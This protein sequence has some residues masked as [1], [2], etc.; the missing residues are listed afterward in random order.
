MHFDLSVWDSTAQETKEFTT[1]QRSHCSQ[2]APWYA[3]LSSF[4][5]A[6]ADE[7]MRVLN[8]RCIDPQENDI[9]V[10]G[11]QCALLLNRRDVASTCHK[12]K[13]EEEGIVKSPDLLLD[14]EQMAQ[15]YEEHAGG[16]NIE[17][18][19]ITLRVT[20]CHDGVPLLNG[21]ND[22]VI[23]NRLRCTVLASKSR[24]MR[25]LKRTIPFSL[26]NHDGITPGDDLVMAKF[27][28]TCVQLCELSWADFGLDMVGSSRCNDDED[29]DKHAKT[30]A[31]NI[32]HTRS[33]E[34]ASSMHHLHCAALSCQRSNLESID[35]IVNIQSILADNDYWKTRDSIST[36]L[37]KKSFVD[38]PLVN[39]MIHMLL[40]SVQ[41]DKKWLQSK[42]QIKVGR[43]DFNVESKHDNAD[44]NFTSLLQSATNSVSAIYPHHQS[45]H[46]T[47][48]C[49]FIQ[50]LFQTAVLL[51]ARH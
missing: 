37:P 28:P 11:I 29:L 47:Y 19:R 50:S 25:S 46:P 24:M 51:H 5:S 12:G 45:E 22:Q 4:F 33:A 9:S 32:E 48:H 17:N 7:M 44:T 23:K 18:D 36:S 1:T 21:Y 35:I 10:Q 27:E 41:I 20:I 2:G 34:T 26:A 43:V 8:A 15:D 30:E 49:P 13:K 39:C 42:R 6:D 31:G 14:M 40:Q 38:Q 16:L 3:N